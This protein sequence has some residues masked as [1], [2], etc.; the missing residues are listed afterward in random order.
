VPYSFTLSVELVLVDDVRV[1]VQHCE[2]LATLV[3]FA[4]TGV[5]GISSVSAD[6]LASYV[7]E[8]AVHVERNPE[9]GQ[10]VRRKIHVH[11]SAN[12]VAQQDV[13]D[14]Q[15]G[16]GELQAALLDLV[17]IPSNRQLSVLRAGKGPWIWDFDILLQ[18]L[19]A[20]RDSVGLLRACKWDA[21]TV[22]GGL[23]IRTSDAQVRSTRELLVSDSGAIIGA[24]ANFGSGDFKRL[25]LYDRLFA[26][27]S[28]AEKA[29]SG[30]YVST[31]AS[32][33]TAFAYELSDLQRGT[34]GADPALYIEPDV[35]LFD[36]RNGTQYLGV[37][38]QMDRWP[39]DVRRHVLGTTEQLNT[40]E[41][42][43]P[44]AGNLSDNVSPE[45]HGSSVTA[46]LL[47]IGCGIGILVLIRAITTRKVSPK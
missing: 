16:Q 17:Y 33:L 1:L 10:V 28:G 12:A 45:T 20:G 46:A 43:Q 36:F 13:V 15:Q 37:A 4:E 21:S 34:A 31:Q 44:A 18:P 39:T 41:V 23:G 32:T 30:A 25:A 2:S 24:S 6:E 9:A 22:A 29:A 7:T 47:V 35:K 3:A 19:V 8:A 11:R 38:A 26:C 40:E 5:L 14:G 27:I 42:G